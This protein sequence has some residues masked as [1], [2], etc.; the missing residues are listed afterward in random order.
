MLWSRVLQISDPNAMAPSPDPLPMDVD[1]LHVLILA[2]RA[3]H[4]RVTAR[5]INERDAAVAERER[6]A[7]SRIG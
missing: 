7:D 1:A 5:M 6:W 3:A 2:E 4:A